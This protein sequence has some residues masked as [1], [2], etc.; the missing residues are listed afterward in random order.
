MDII[1]EPPSPVGA[2]AAKQQAEMFGRIRG[3]GRVGPPYPIPH[4]PIRLDPWEML[5][6]LAAAQGV[7]ADKLER[8]LDN[9]G[10]RLTW[11]ELVEDANWAEV[12]QNAPCEDKE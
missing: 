2:D 10:P 5:T 8:M 3:I 4:Y 11:K 7:L 9:Q 12:A 6:D 1:Q